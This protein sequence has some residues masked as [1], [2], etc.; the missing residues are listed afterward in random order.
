MP[1]EKVHLHLHSQ[2]WSPVWHTT[3]TLNKG[4]M[5]CQQNKNNNNEKK[6]KK[7]KNLHFDTKLFSCTQS[8]L[9][10]CSHIY[11]SVFILMCCL[12]EK[13]VIVKCLTV[14]MSL[15]AWTG[16]IVLNLQRAYTFYSLYS[17]LRFAYL[18]LNLHYSCQTLWKSFQ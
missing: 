15:L 14:Q 5:L 6:K 11:D 4:W 1:G 12:K 7:K 18:F 3:R 16:D 8:F 2:R 10:L 17:W 13:L 9:I